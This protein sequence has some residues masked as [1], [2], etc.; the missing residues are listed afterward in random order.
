[1]EALHG[2]T[3]RGAKDAA[4]DSPYQLGVRYVCYPPLD[5]MTTCCF[6]ELSRMAV[7]TF[8]SSIDYLLFCCSL[9]AVGLH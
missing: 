1:M 4:L 9:E 7:L 3:S 8:M 2:D 6:V 5:L